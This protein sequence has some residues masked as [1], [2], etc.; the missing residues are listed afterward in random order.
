MA[1]L[2]NNSNICALS[3]WRQLFASQST[4]RS[5]EAYAHWQAVERLGL[6]TCQNEYWKYTPLD[7]LLAHRF[8]YVTT[9]AVSSTV[10]DT[11]SLTMDAYRLVFINGRFAPALSDNDTGLWQIKI[12]EG[13][14]RRA[15]SAP[16][17]TEVFLHLIESLSQETTRIRLP[18]GK[19]AKRPLYLLHISQ[20]S[21]DKEAL[22]TLY[23]RHHI[24]I[25]SCAK[26]QIIEHF[27]SI[28]S[29][30]HFSGART[31]FSVGDNANLTQI[32]LA[33]ESCASYHFSHN[34]IIIDRDATVRS[35]TFILGAEL[36]QHQIS[37]Q[38]NGEGSNLTI[39][40]LLLPSGKGISDIRTYL[41]HNKG[42]CLS[43]QLHKI[44]ARDRGKGVFNGLI[45]VAKH[46]LKTDS[47]MANNNLLL[48]RL[49][50]VNTKP[51]L[52][53]YAD[54]VKCSHSA[55]VVQID[56][57]QMFYLRSR[58]ITYK[59]AQQMIIYAF[60]EEVTETIGHEGVRNIVL[61]RI[62][63]ALDEGVT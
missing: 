59:D 49:T 50:E 3:Q 8:A 31:T 35:S 61:A 37:A 54:D 40:S 42:H 58:G 60:A 16:I 19:M 57:K 24:D 29:Q 2:P 45:K 12:E 62:T 51:H 10:R 63:D 25:E 28:D 7:K 26:G 38:L 27:T 39:N 17:Q 21:E 46:A 44:V 30:K 53:I 32:E 56:E 6:P 18:A 36:T 41:E 4:A 43:R 34:D 1:G 55:T 47:Q 15:L 23:Y 11:L 20:G 13:A 22:N 14:T 48:D 33:F 5:V 52:E 9:R